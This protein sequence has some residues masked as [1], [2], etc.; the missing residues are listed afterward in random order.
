MDL[1]NRVFDIF[2]SNRVYLTILFFLLG[3]M[4]CFATP[5][6]ADPTLNLGARMEITVDSET[7]E[8]PLI[9]NEEGTGFTLATQ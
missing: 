2:R 9:L 4:C 3:L 5:S 6:L 1:N 8:I 7:Q